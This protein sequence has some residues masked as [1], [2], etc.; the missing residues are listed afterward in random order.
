ME[1]GEND[2][3]ACG[4]SLHLPCLLGKWLAKTQRRKERYLSDSVNM[5][6]PIRGADA[7]FSRVGR[8]L[9]AVEILALPV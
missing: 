5:M 6:E 2:K 9:P 8:L 3:V 7:R 1:R 4:T